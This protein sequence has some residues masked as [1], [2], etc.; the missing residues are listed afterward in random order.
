MRRYWQR[1]LVVSVGI[2]LALSFDLPFQ[3]AFA[4]EKNPRKLIKIH[5]TRDVHYLYEHGR[6]PEE[7]RRGLDT[8]G[9][10]GLF[11][12]SEPEKTP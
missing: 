5:E 10:C 12:E 3:Q 9:G 7:Q 2:L 8:Q 4:A 11:C 1:G 6:F